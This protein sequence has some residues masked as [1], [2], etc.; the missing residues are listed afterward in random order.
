[1]SL[2]TELGLEALPDKCYVVIEIAL[3]NIRTAQL[4]GQIRAPSKRQ[5][6]VQVTTRQL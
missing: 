5:P 2:L 3:A 1:M 4:N 6:P